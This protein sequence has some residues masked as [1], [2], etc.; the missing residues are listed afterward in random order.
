MVIRRRLGEI[1]VEAGLLNATRLDAA[2]MLQSV[3]RKRLGS[4]LLEA[5]MVD[6]AGLLGC[7]ARQ[8][9]LP[10]ADLQ[11]VACDPQALQFLPCH[12][13]R[14]YRAF[15]LALRNRGR[16]QHLHL[17][18]ADPGNLAAISEIE[19][20]LGLGV[21]PALALESA[22]LGVIDRHYS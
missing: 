5:K 20:T 14:R 15:P 16:H 2:L 13:A 22:I 8:L 19:F 9:H 11:D 3:R 12:A 1:L 4:T 10:V 18:M 17:A 6:A 7:L 21:Q